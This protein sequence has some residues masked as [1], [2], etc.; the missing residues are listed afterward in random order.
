MDV[1]AVCSSGTTTTSSSATPAAA[2][3]GLEQ[4]AEQEPRLARLS[5]EAMLQNPSANSSSSATV[6]PTVSLH[7]GKA[8]TDAPALFIDKHSEDLLAKTPCR[9]PLP[10]P[11]SGLLPTPPTQPPV[12]SFT[13]IHMPYAAAMR[14]QHGAC[15]QQ[16]NRTPLQHPLQDAASFP[17]AAAHVTGMVT[18]SPVPARPVGRFVLDSGK[19][20]RP[21]SQPHHGVGFVIQLAC[22][23][24]LLL[25]VD[26]VCPLAWPATGAQRPVRRPANNPPLLILLHSRCTIMHWP[27]ASNRVAIVLRIRRPGSRFTRTPNTLPGLPLLLPPGGGRGQH[28]GALPPRQ[29]GGAAPDAL[30]GARDA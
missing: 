17:S 23:Q 19:V 4:Q 2:N 25:F 12:L 30:R 20:G 21:A 18:P 9:P 29:G 8:A 16:E 28:G 26:P 1:A 5:N 6:V 3:V 7:A 24:R 13:P 10:E 15:E 14:S 27:L 11:S 22:H